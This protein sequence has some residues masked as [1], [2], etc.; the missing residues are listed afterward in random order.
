M[1]ITRTW[2]RVVVSLATMLFRLWKLFH[3]VLAL[4]RQASWEETT[5]VTNLCWH[6]N[7]ENRACKQVRFHSILDGS[8]L[9]HAIQV[10]MG[11][12]LMNYGRMRCTEMKRLLGTEL[13]THTDMCFIPW[14]WPRTGLSRNNFTGAFYAGNF[15][16]W[17]SNHHIRFMS[18]SQQPP[19]THPATLRLAP[20][21]FR[22]CRFGS[23]VQSACRLTA[24]I[25][26]CL[27]MTVRHGQIH[28]FNSYIYIIYFYGFSSS[29]CNLNNQLG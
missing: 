22:I 13:D 2:A 29:L 12:L 11:P 14:R 20:H 27:V 10:L 18:S 24:S 6:G 4:G 15:R 3:A 7:N 5:L 23:G 26:L 28:H 19:A 8:S 16:E 1:K 9:A 21:Q 17:S 25:F